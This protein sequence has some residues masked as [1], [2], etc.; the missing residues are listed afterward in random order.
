MSQLIAPFATVDAPN[1]TIDFLH[2]HTFTLQ[3]LEIS[4]KSYNYYLPKPTSPQMSQLTPHLPHLAPQMSQLIFTL[5]HAQPL[6]ITG[7]QFLIFV[8]QE[9]LKSPQM[10]QLTPQMSQL[11]RCIPCNYWC[12]GFL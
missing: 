9:I 8:L 2:S 7:F 10:S 1:V 4:T 3:C 5:N 12:T 11:K 6:V